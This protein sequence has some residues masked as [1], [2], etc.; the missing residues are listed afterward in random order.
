[1]K[2]RDRETW[3]QRKTERTH[4]DIHTERHRDTD[5]DR[6]NMWR[7]TENLR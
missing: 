3:C 2:D 4:R 7:A 5:R 1:M 6:E